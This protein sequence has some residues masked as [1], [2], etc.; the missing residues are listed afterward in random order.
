ML[1]KSPCYELHIDAISCPDFVL[2]ISYSNSSPSELHTLVPANAIYPGPD[3]NISPPT[4]QCM[5]YNSWDGYIYLVG[6]S[7]NDLVS[8]MGWVIY[9]LN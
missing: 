7:R 2:N 3:D 8:L 4:V 9:L 5:A 1:I 6:W